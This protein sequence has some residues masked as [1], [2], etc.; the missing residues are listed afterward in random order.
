MRIWTSYADVEKHVDTVVKI[1]RTC[2]KVPVGLETRIKA[3]LRRCKRPGLELRFWDKLIEEE[4]KLA[5]QF[6]I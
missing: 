2:G 6:K 3:S 4:P 1:Y 5:K